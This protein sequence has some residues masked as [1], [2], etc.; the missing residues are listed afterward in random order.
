MSNESKKALLNEATTKRFWKLAGLRPIHEKAYVFDEG[1]DLEEEK[2]EEETEELEE[3][4]MSYAAEDEPEDEM[5]DEEMPP[6]AEA[7]SDM[8]PEPDADDEMDVEVDVPEGDIASLKTA[9][10]II[11][12]ILSAVG[13]AAEE[14][15]EMEPGDEPEEPSEELE[16]EHEFDLDEADRQELEEVAEKIASIALQ[17]TP[18]IRSRSPG[19]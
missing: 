6:E 11:D 15:P 8:E 12:Q 19:Q 10:D 17:K 13:T 4:G 1:E 16:E 9:R 2:V 14:E 7:P 18:K 3:G 5:G